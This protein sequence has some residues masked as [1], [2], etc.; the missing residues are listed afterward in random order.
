MSNLLSFQAESEV[1][2][3]GEHGLSWPVKVLDA[4][5]DG[6]IVKFTIQTNIVSPLRLSL[7]L[8]KSTLVILGEW[9][10]DFNP[11]A[12]P[13]NSSQTCKT[14]L[15][16]EIALEFRFAIT[17]PSFMKFGRVTN[18]AGHLPFS[19]LL[20]LEDC[21]NTEISVII[22]IHYRPLQ[23][24]R[25]GLLLLLLFSWLINLV[26]SSREVMSI[27]LKVFILRPANSVDFF[28]AIRGWVIKNCR[29]AKLNIKNVKR[30]YVLI[31]SE[32]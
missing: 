18:P 22:H 12:F 17:Y 11:S 29:F 4:S 16:N 2:G 20:Q 23:T 24:D 14:I 8:L 32:N 9:Y 3:V 26:I 7:I 13:W 31:P 5:K 27:F 25:F 1:N 10:C 30:R 15:K 28:K 21:C 6:E 19:P